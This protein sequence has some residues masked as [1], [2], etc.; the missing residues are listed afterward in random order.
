MDRKTDPPRGTWWNFANQEYDT[1]PEELSDEWAKE[2]LSQHV[3]AQA[4]YDIH[5]KLGDSIL[6]AMRKVLHAQIGEEP[7]LLE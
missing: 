3:A 5:R 6:E 7:P 4:L 2:H 1:Q